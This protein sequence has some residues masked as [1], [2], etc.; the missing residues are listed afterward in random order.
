MTLKNILS[1]DDVLL[2]RGTGSNEHEIQ[3]EQWM[4]WK[5]REKG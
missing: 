4:I 3:L 2:G 1:A 5:K